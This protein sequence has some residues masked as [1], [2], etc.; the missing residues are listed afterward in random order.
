M[1]GGTVSRCVERVTP[2]PPPEREAHTLARP[3]VT[4]WSVTFQPR[5]TSHFDT[6]STAPFSAPV[7]ESMVNSSA[8]SATTS[9]MSPKL[10]APVPTSQFSGEHPASQ[11]EEVGA[12]RTAGVDG[13]IFEHVEHAA[14]HR[15]A[16]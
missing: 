6:K 4:S 15:A 10:A 9:V 8:A 14:L 11:L 1:Y 13:P 7:D 12:K 3:R 2:R 5:A 16:G